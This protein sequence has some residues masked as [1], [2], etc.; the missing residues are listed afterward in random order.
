MNVKKLFIGNKYFKS[1]TK[2]IVYTHTHTN[3][4][5]TQTHTHEHISMT[6]PKST[7][8]QFES[9]YKNDCTL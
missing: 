2:Y 5:H 6:H 1:M 7:T 9:G 8:Y 3:T 4:P